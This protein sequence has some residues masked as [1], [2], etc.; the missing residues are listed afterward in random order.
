MLRDINKTE[1][2]YTFSKNGNLEHKRSEEEEC[3]TKISSPQTPPMDT[4]PKYVLDNKRTPLINNSSFKYI[5]NLSKSDVIQRDHTYNN[6]SNINYYN[7]KDSTLSDCKL[8][9]SFWSV[10]KTYSF[11]FPCEISRDE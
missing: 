9:R 6:S 2:R 3:P 11:L 8:L 1:T 10:Y 4:T 7:N 5:E